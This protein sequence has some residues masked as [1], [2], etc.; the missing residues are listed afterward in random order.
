MSAQVSKPK[1][2]DWKQRA[3]FSDDKWSHCHGAQ[4]IF[5]P[6]GL[7]YDWYDEPAER[8]C[9]QYFWRDSQAKFTPQQMQALE[10]IQCWCYLDKDYTDDTLKICA[11]SAAY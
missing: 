9:D 3:V 6:H 5:G 2:A 4:G 8:H 10:A 1:G 11:Y 7:F